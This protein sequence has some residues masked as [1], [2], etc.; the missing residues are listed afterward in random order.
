MGF[1][2]IFPPDVQT[3]FGAAH[4]AE[5]PIAHQGHQNIVIDGVEVAWMSAST[6]HHP[7]TRFCLISSTACKSY[8]WSSDCYS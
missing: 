1:P 6:T 3:E 7:R 4:F 5:C 8:G 2:S